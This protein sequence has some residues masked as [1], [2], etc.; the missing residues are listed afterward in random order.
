MFENKAI[1]NGKF[2]L[3]LGARKFFAHFVREVGSFHEIQQH[4]AVSDTPGVRRFDHHADIPAGRE[5]V[6]A[7]DH[8]THRYI[9]VLS[10]HSQIDRDNHIIGGGRLYFVGRYFIDVQR[11]RWM[12]PQGHEQRLP[13]VKKKPNMPCIETVQAAGANPLQPI[14][15]Q[16]LTT[17]A[18]FW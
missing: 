13:Q 2:F 7:I 5:E 1:T 11:K 9:P 14:S 4:H 15:S 6:D 8:I 10:E 16:L 12:E 3:Q 18:L 17:L